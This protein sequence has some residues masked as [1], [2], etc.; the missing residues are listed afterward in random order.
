M[1]VNKVNKIEDQVDVGEHGHHQLTV[2][3]TLS[4]RTVLRTS[5]VAILPVKAEDGPDEC[6]TEIEDHSEEGVDNHKPVK[7]E[8]QGRGP[9]R[10]RQY[11]HYHGDQEAQAVHHHTVL[12]GNVD[13]V[14]AIVG[15]RPENNAG[16]KSLDHLE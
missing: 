6:S 13:I 15:Q 3:G 11:N 2:P 4:T 9:P 7:G 16:H 8:P 5:S 14:F 12:G 1:R 10:N